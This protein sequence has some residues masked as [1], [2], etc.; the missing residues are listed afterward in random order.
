MIKKILKAFGKEVEK[1][2]IDSPSIAFE[3]F[4]TIDED[5]IDI[6]DHDGELT[7]I[8][9]NYFD[10]VKEVNTVRLFAKNL[11]DI[12]TSLNEVKVM[13]SVTLGASKLKSIPDFVFNSPQLVSLTIDSN[14]LR[15]TD[16]I[17]ELNQI[18]QLSIRGFYGKKWPEQFGQFTQLKKL[19]IG[20][21]LKKKVPHLEMVQ[22]IGDLKALELLEISF[23]LNMEEIQD[24][25]V[26]L[27]G[28]QEIQPAI[29][30]VDK[31]IVPFSLLKESNIKY[32]EHLKI[33]FSD[34]SE[35]QKIANQYELT[36]KQRKT[37]F[38]TFI[39][40]VDLASEWIENKMNDWS[41]ETQQVIHFTNRP[42]RDIIQK[43]KDHLPHVVLKVN[44][45]IETGEW[46]VINTKTKPEVLADAF[47]KGIEVT[48]EDALKELLVKVE[49]PWLRQ[50]ENKESNEQVYQLIG[51]NQPENILLAFQIISGGG[52]TE[53]IISMV[54]ALMMAHPDKQV[55]K[56]AEKLFKLIGP[57]STYATIKSSGI[58]LRRSGNTVKKVNQ[59][60]QTDIGIL[61]MPFRIM[62][63]VIAHDNPNIADMYY[64]RLSFKQADLKEPI[65]E[66]IQ[67]FQQ[68]EE[69]D[70]EKATNIN[71]KEALPRLG[72]MSQVKKVFL[73]GCKEE[74]G[75]EI[76]ELK[77]LEY[78]DLSTNKVLDST[79]L[80]E[81]THLKWLNVEGC[82]IKDWS[83]LEKLPQLKFLNASRNK[84]TVIPAPIV[85][86]T[87][88]EELLL[89]Q[90]KVS[91]IPEELYKKRLIDLDLSNNMISEIDYRVFTIPGLEKLSLRTNKIKEFK[92]EKIQ[93]ASSI[94]YL[95]MAGNSITSF[96]VQATTFSYLYH[97]NLSKNQLKELH[98]SVIMYT[99]LRDLYLSEND[100]SE[101]PQVLAGKYFEHLH[102]QKNKIEELPEFVNKIR[103]DNLDIRNNNIKKIHPSIT[104]SGNSYSRYYWNLSGNPVDRIPYE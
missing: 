2:G 6:F 96:Q 97:L 42:H 32:R 73:T 7:T 63:M 46:L 36:A 9:D 44:K 49:D 57:T 95:N 98:K 80:G 29:Y 90:N 56:E 5:G 25:I 17:L 20:H 53:E 16:D 51:S 11:T 31:D 45:P 87:Q 60:F 28:I 40:R 50:D 86:H 19:E 43:I 85:E 12:P 75:S 69:V 8:P 89:K 47:V 52:A 58:S 61:E 22:N 99:R 35:F 66:M 76:G 65:P 101:L 30:Q 84:L 1:E 102:I 74:I 88:I 26:L 23:P 93:G 21:E 83:F 104:M 92:G 81:L 54:A 3:K 67:Y 79:A 55:A 82:G 77:Q 33:E 41:A 37:L 24:S 18:Q 48:S 13:K 4:I 15:I 70:F 10:Q 64:P 78:L 62:H 94:K 71:P 14:Q 103:I 38:C 100:I 27:D 39:N 91:V 72:K 34:L 68:I 59:L